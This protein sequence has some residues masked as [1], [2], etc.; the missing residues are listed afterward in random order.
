[1]NIRTLQQGMQK[2][3]DCVVKNVVGGLRATLACCLLGSVL[4][5][6]ATA[7]KT[8]DVDQEQDI[9]AVEQ[10]AVEKQDQALA[11]TPTAT[12]Q[13]R[14][15]TATA[16]SV[17][18]PEPEPVSETETD[19]DAMMAKL[20]APVKEPVSKSSAEKNTPAVVEVKTKADSGAEAK[21]EA[22]AK[23][24]AEVEARLAAEA[25]LKA[26]AEAQAMAEAQARMETQARLE[27][28]AKAQEAAASVPKSAAGAAPLTAGAKG[29]PVIVDYWTIAKGE[30]VLDKEIVIT[31]RTWEM[32]KA[33]FSSQVW[34]T[35]MDDKMLVNSSSGIDPET[36]GSGVKINGGK[37]IPYSR[38]EGNNIAVIEGNWLDQLVGGGKLD[39]Y[40]G[41]FPDRKTRSDT[42]QSDISLDA[43]AR[44][45][46]TYRKMI[47]K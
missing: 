40:L 19:A 5:G 46:P 47:G 9:S 44:V 26:E 24:K 31:T 34:L 10:S 3:D 6:C 32:G 11:A 14:V 7:D 28:E 38:I 25:K 8:K 41:F 20:A 43:L 13:S 1:M 27:A 37:L 33:G 29:L 39:I 16:E 45:I 12:T 21:A 17:P 18:E 35:I 15:E 36:S 30:A 23:A 42:F 2:V 22:E 4:V